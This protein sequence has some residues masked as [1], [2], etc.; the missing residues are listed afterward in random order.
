M[1]SRQERN[2]VACVVQFGSGQRSLPS[3]KTAILTFVIALF[4]VSTIPHPAAADGSGSLENYSAVS[5]DSTM[6][7]TVTYV[8]NYDQNKLEGVVNENTDPDSLTVTYQGYAVAEYNPQFW[9]TC[10][11]GKPV[12]APEDWFTI[13]SYDQG[14]TNTYV[15]AG[16][17]EDENWQDHWSGTD[18]P[19][20]KDSL[21]DPG[22]RLDFNDGNEKTLYAMWSNIT[23]L[24]RVTDI[25]AGAP[26]RLGDDYN[27]PPNFDSGNKYTNI[28]LVDGA[29][30]YGGN[31]TAYWTTLSAESTAG[32]TLRS[33]GGGSYL[34]VCGDPE[35]DWENSYFY[36]FTGVDIIIDNIRLIGHGYERD[37][38]AYGIVAGGNQVI[39][40][41]NV[42]VEKAIDIYGGSYQDWNITDDR[43]DV[44]MF[45]GTFNNIYGS[46]YQDN[47]ASSNVVV[48]GVSSVYSVYGGGHDG[49]VSSDAVIHVNVV[50]GEVRGSVY[51]GSRSIDPEAGFWEQNHG[52]GK[53]QATISLIVADGAQI[54]GSV[55]GGGL[56]QYSPED[57]ADYAP[58]DSP[59]VSISVF[60][61]DV[62]GS[63]Y[64]GG[65]NADLRTDELMIVI[66]DSS[67][68]T[69]G[70][71]V[72]GV[73]GGGHGSLTTADTGISLS[74]GGP[75][76][77][78]I[79]ANGGDVSFTGYVQTEGSLE[80]IRD[81]GSLEVGRSHIV[82]DGDDSG[83]SLD[84]IQSVSLTGGAT[85]DLRS[86]VS[87][88]GSFSSSVMTADGTHRLATIED[89]SDMQNRNAVRLAEGV[90]LDLAN[91][92]GYGV[93]SGWT[94]LDPTLG[95]LSQVLACGSTGSEGG[96]VIDEGSGLEKVPYEDRSGARVWIYTAT[97]DMQD[98]PR[99]V[100]FVFISE[101]RLDDGI[102][103]DDPSLN[104]QI[105]FSA[106]SDGSVTA[107]Y[108]P[109]PD[110]GGGT[111]H[112]TGMP[113]GTGAFGF[114]SEDSDTVLWLVSVGTPEDMPLVWCF[115]DD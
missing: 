53:V 106:I 68:G 79:D 33:E 72:T 93:V 102:R 51:G 77:G 4:L 15:F 12:K 2:A 83:N 8:N 70:A 3:R 113:E 90:V 58:V 22:D 109:S 23:G 65:L 1:M 76:I 40:G 50:G 95:S 10:M 49:S 69:A 103:I 96:F 19:G 71:T 87:Y 115:N 89:C 47:D 74:S 111:I 11:T 52:S 21:I 97:L 24:H 101:D 35:E 34:S 82:L 46:S 32:F 28:V 88:I 18:S 67:I 31:T 37:M 92:Q 105:G 9:S 13:P 73:F 61:S 64:G 94:L 56:N 36:M 38:P 54:R 7:Y 114:V 26:N 42:T 44:R 25:V 80:C 66:D 108:V 85:L 48:A 84:D 39:I 30:Y 63:V 55:Y 45:S 5:V 29:L 57:S 98:V 110:S 17:T 112:I 91:G 99:T 78:E 100:I 27:D 75:I 60:Y 20:Y 41:A 107:E 43:T 16:W 6:T 81:V 104:G 86:E 59:K 62:D 14:N